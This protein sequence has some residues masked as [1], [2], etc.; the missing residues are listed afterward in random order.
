MEE[1]ELVELGDSSYFTGRR[2]GALSVVAL[3]RS[4]DSDDIDLAAPASEVD[5]AAHTGGHDGRSLGDAPGSVVAGPARIPVASSDIPTTSNSA[6]QA[7]AI[8]NQKPA[9]LRRRMM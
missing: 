8:Q 7:P 6:T 4:G 3:V 9:S 2:S 5:D 1:N